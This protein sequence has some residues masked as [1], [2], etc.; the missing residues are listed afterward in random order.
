MAIKP[1]QLTTIGKVLEKLEPDD[2]DLF[3]YAEGS[4]PYKAS[5][6]AMMSLVRGD[7]PDV[8]LAPPA[9]ANGLKYVV[10]GGDLLDLF[11]YLDRNVQDHDADPVDDDDR[12]AALN[13]YLIEGRPLS[14][15]ED[16]DPETY[17]IES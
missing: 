2:S 11:A 9:K 1:D 5:A 16:L 17:P 10:S 13:H 4:A 8:D 15:L 6:K 12:L 7:L 3:L 14:L